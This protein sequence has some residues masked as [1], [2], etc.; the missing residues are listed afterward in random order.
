MKVTSTPMAACRI[1][2]ADLPH[3]SVP[4]RAQGAVKVLVNF[5]PWSRMGDLNT[6]HLKPCGAVCCTHTAPIAV[7]SKKVFVMGQG[8]G[9]VTDKVAGCTAV[10]TGSPNV[11]CTI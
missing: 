1:G 3:C 5:I 6:P 10:A 7:G 11:F 2:D 4:F 9:R 8:A